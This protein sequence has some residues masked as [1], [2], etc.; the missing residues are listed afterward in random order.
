MTIYHALALLCTCFA[1]LCLVL[2]YTFDLYRT[3][4]HWRARYNLEHELVELEKATGRFDREARER[5]AATVAATVGV[6]AGYNTKA[7]VDGDDAAREYLLDVLR[8][9]YEGHNS[10]SRVAFKNR[11]VLHECFE[12]LRSDPDS[13][14][15]ITRD[16]TVGPCDATQIPGAIRMLLGRIADPVEHE[17]IAANA[18][19]CPGPNPLTPAPTVGLDSAES[20]CDTAFARRAGR[21]SA[22]FRL[23]RRLTNSELELLK[24]FNTRFALFFLSDDGLSLTMTTIAGEG[25]DFVYDDGAQSLFKIIVERDRVLEGGIELH[26]LQKIIVT[27]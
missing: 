25:N 24:R 1:V 16:G 4:D 23:S 13:L 17:F 5:F 26:P 7:T 22:D 8:V 14:A 20:A 15:W 2:T 11:V 21:Y 9:L 19:D 12:A 6:L 10:E 27:E 18:D 3:R